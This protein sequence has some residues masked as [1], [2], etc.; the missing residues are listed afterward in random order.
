VYHRNQ[1]LHDESDPLPGAWNATGG[2]CAH[3]KSVSG[4]AWA[5]LLSL[6]E[7]RKGVLGGPM[8]LTSL[9]NTIIFH[10]LRHFDTFPDRTQSILR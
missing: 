7:A 6:L 4:P 3:P 9:G 10:K 8:S 5:C 2:A 1:R